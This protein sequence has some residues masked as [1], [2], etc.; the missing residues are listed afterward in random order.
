MEISVRPLSAPDLDRVCEIEEA[1]FSMP[2]KRADFEHLIE[3]SGSEYFVVAADGYVVGTA[4][5]TDQVGEG[6]V[7]NVAVDTRYRGLGLSKILM[8]EILKAGFKKGITDFTLEVRVGNTAAV[9]LYKSLGFESAGIRKNFYERPVEDAYVM[10]L[11]GFK[12]EEEN[13]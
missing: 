9:G 5:Y 4:G 7:N 2:W 10:W 3:D 12:P 1:C 13:A 8:L 11:R 6:Y